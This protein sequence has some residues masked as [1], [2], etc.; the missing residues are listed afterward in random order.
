MYTNIG[1]KLR[2]VWPSVILGFLAVL[3]T[4]PIYVFYWKGS[5]IRKR[6]KFAQELASDREARRMSV[7]VDA[8][9]AMLERNEI[10]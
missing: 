7:G 9:V 5:A 6:S 10:A 3:V 2:L 4:I 8:Q 1:T